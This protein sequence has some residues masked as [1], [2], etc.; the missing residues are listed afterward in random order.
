MFWDSNKRLLSYEITQKNEK[1]PNISVRLMATLIASSW[2]SWVLAGSYAFLS[3]REVMDLH[4]CKRNSK[5]WWMELRNWKART[6]NIIWLW[7]P[8]TTSKVTESG[9]RDKSAVKRT[10]WSC[11]LPKMDSQHS[12]QPPITP[13][14]STGM[15]MCIHR[16]IHINLI[17]IRL[18]LF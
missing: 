3:Q 15:H 4:V 16:H 11:R 5:T 12:S 2:K 10:C 17:H 6:A 7:L 1:F 14:M 8:I 9:W 18:I 13:D